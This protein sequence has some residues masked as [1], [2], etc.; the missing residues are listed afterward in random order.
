MNH[1]KLSIPTPCHESW[2]DM[3]P[4]AQG[5]FCG[6]CQKTVTDFSGMTNDQIAIYIH[7]NA[8]EKMCGRFKKTQLESIIIQVPERII[9]TQTSFRRMFMLALLVVMGTTLLSCADDFGNK[10]PI[11]QVVVVDSITGVNND[12][13]DLPLPYNERFIMGAVAVNKSDTL[14]DVPPPPPPIEDYEPYKIDQEE[15]EIPN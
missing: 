8:G 10:Q 6:Q 7:L 9:Y 1:F 12:S 3:T 13:I 11:E 2:E 5:K 14:D 4:N 15:I